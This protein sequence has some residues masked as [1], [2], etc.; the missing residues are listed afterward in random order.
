M[1]S[2]ARLAV[3]RVCGLILLTGVALKIQGAMAGGVGQSLGNFSPRVQLAAIEI[4]AL[5][6]LWLVSGLARQGAWFAGVGLY[7]VL[8]GVSLYLVSAGVSNCRCFGHVHV[9]PWTSFALDATCL[10]GLVLTRPADM[11]EWFHTPMALVL[12]AAAAV[13]AILLLIL[14][15][16]SPAA[17]RQFALLRGEALILE[18][19]DTNVGAAQSG[20]YRWVEVAVENIS[21]SDARL[22]GGT[23]DCSCLSTTDLPVTI[24]PGGRSVIHVAIRFGGSPGNFKHSFRLYTDVPTQPLLYGFVHGRVDEASERN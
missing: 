17:N 16:T 10:A 4:E 6:G 3:A 5:V 15:G 12:R 9:S 18:A 24:S 19:E 1:S 11:S 23:A 13:V 20:D 14:G 22:V 7:S 8:A 2:P 21:N